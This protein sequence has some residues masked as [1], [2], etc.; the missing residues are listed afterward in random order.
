M[1]EVCSKC[2]DRNNLLLDQGKHPQKAR[3]LNRKKNKLDEIPESFQNGNFRTGGNSNAE[4]DDNMDLKRGSCLFKT[5][6]SS[7]TA[8]LSNSDYQ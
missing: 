8:A 6:G 7:R 4:Y 5:G 1:G 3:P 2:E